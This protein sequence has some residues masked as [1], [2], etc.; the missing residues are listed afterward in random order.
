VSLAEYPSLVE[1]ELAAGRLES[2]GIESRIDQQG[3]I[4]LFGPGHSGST[5]GGVRV[6]VLEGDLEAAR[7]ALDL[8]ASF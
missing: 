2:A 5:L 4:G 7:T 8:E 6:L 1:A 3:N